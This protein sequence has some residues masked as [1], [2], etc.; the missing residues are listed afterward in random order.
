MSDFTLAH[1]ERGRAASSVASRGRT[2]NEQETWHVPLIDR[3]GYDR[4]LSLLVKKHGAEYLCRPDGEPLALVDPQGIPR[5]EVRLTTG[6]QAHK[7]KPRPAPPP[8]AKEKDAAAGMSVRD[9][10]LCAVRARPMMLREIVTYT[11]LTQ[12]QVKACLTR[13]AST[14]FRR[15]GHVWEERQ[16][17]VSV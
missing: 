10:V 2:V 11:G 17:V 1:A 9:Q 13:Y 15:N 3:I 4:F 12:G 6:Y 5:G 8:P 14:Y 16:N 7:Y